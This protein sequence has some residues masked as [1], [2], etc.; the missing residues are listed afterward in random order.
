M[1]ARRNLILAVILC[2]VVV[3]V[4]VPAIAA[5]SSPLSTTAIR[6]AYFIGNRRDSQTDDFLAQYV[7][8]FSNPNTDSYID[9][10]EIETPFTQIVR[11]SEVAR[12]YYAPDA[13]EEFEAKP[14]KFMVEVEIAFNSDYPTVTGDAPQLAQWIPDFWNDYKVHLIQDHEIMPL[15]VRG[16]PVYAYGWKHMPLVTGGHIQVIYDSEKL[17]ADPIT[18]DVIAPDGQKTETSFNLASL[19]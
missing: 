5:F 15:S 6:D 11:H 3:G 1:P 2:A 19:R 17:T 14:L 9:A 12:N 4:A 7:H 8:Q 18:I 16:G 13:V 10:I